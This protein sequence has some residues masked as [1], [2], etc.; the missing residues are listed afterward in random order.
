MLE[1]D[2]FTHSMKALKDGMTVQC[3]RRW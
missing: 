3:T 1:Q 2:A